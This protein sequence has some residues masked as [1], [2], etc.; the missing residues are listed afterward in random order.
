MDNNKITLEVI[1]K[2]VKSL[3]LYSSHVLYISKDMA[4]EGLNDGIFERNAFWELK[5]VGRSVKVIIG[6]P[7]GK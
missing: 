4:R 7:W 1:D 6:S 5:V 2:A 3:D